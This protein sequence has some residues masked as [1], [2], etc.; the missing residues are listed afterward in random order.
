MLGGASAQVCPGFD[1]EPLRFAYYQPAM[2]ILI[3][4]GA[5]VALL[6]AAAIAGGYALSAPGGGWWPGF[7]AALCYLLGA[8]LVLIG[9]FDL[10]FLVVGYDA[11]AKYFKNALLTPAVVVSEKPLVLVGLAPLGN[12]EGP[13]YSGLQRVDLN[14]SGL[15]YHPRKRGERVPCVSAFERG[16]GL[17][18]WL[19]FRPEP[20]SWGTG[21]RRRIDACF[22]RLGD[23]DFDRLDAL[24][25]SGLVPKDADELILLDEDDRRLESLSIREQKEKHRPKES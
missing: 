22:D 14:M 25:A 9:L 7:L 8:C 13:G 16:E 21:S 10:L 24:I 15:P 17:D 11:A 1:P 12:G 2:R 3:V 6:A 23:A 5:V 19:C 20:I 18:R 4:F